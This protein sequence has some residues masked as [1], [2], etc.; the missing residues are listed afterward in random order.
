MF[1][2]I[3]RPRALVNAARRVSAT[4]KL[5]TCARVIWYNRVSVGFT[6]SRLR[7]N[8]LLSLEYAENH[9]WP[10]RT[11]P[12]YGIVLGMD[13]K[14]TRKLQRGIDILSGDRPLRTKYDRECLEL[15]AKRYGMD[16]E[17]ALSFALF[18][19][20]MNAAYDDHDD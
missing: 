15:V 7:T 2:T 16:Y 18:M 10:L 8:V 11:R 5:A 1:S 4:S 9:C 19:A 17:Q 3:P 14:E 6:L 20:D 13:K 12:V